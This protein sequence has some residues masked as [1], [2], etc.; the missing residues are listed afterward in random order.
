MRHVIMMLRVSAGVCKSVAFVCGLAVLGLTVF[1]ASG[2]VAAGTPLADRIAAALAAALHQQKLYESM[3]FTR[4]A[5]SK[6]KASREMAF[7]GMHFRKSL[8][9]YERVVEL[10]RQAGSTSAAVPR[11]LEARALALSAWGLAGYGTW[12]TGAAGRQIRMA[13]GLAPS[14]PDPDVMLAS[15]YYRRAIGILVGRFGSLDQKTG[16]VRWHNAHCSP[17]QIALRRHCFLKSAFFAEKALRLNPDEPLANFV[18][19]EDLN[20]LKMDRG[21]R[22]YYFA[23]AYKNRDHVKPILFHFSPG[24][25]WNFNQ[26]LANDFGTMQ[27]KNSKLPALLSKLET[28]AWNRRPP[29]LPKLSASA[30]RPD[31]PDIDVHLISGKNVPRPVSLKTG[32]AKN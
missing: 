15:L 4:S 10:L 21:N 18:L 20:V 29:A 11:K 17:A 31:P 13:G 26:N 12:Q 25:L 19:W 22:S 28:G 27:Q 30:D 16:K 32:S 8:Q 9:E 14:D 1:I 23:K 6:E 5:E 7:M 2:A 3:T 24:D